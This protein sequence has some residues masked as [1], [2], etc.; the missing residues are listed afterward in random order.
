MGGRD[1]WK[2]AE[3]EGPRKTFRG[4]LTTRDQVPTRTTRVVCPWSHCCQPAELEFEPRSVTLPRHSALT[5]NFTV[6]TLSSELVP[7]T[8]VGHASLAPPSIQNSSCEAVTEQPLFRR[9][10]GRKQS[11]QDRPCPALP[12]PQGSP[13]EASGAQVRRL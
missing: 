4:C 12:S 7:P 10:A 5:L 1:M 3:V 2:W 6:N 9:G 13:H 8:A 11:G